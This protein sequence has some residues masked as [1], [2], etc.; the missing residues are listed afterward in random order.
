MAKYRKLIAAFVGVLI[1]LWLRF[2]DIDVFGLDQFVMELVISAAT[3]F[4]VYQ[5]PNEID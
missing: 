3:L 2:N 1:L 4:G 5:A